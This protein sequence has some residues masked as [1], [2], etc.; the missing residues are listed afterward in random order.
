L[1]VQIGNERTC[2][3][4]KNEIEVHWRYQSQRLQQEE[5]SHNKTR[6]ELE[7]V[8]NLFFRTNRYLTQC[9]TI[10]LQDSSN[11]KK[12]AQFEQAEQELSP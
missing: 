3:H 5:Q 1:K 2:Q 8:Q 6:S 11:K 4:N 7:K 9:K 10:I 12:W